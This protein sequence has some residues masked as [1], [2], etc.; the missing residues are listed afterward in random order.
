[1][2]LLVILPLFL[3]AMT[4]YLANETNAAIQ[5]D[6]ETDCRSSHILFQRTTAN[7]FVCVSQETAERWED[8]G[9]GKIVG[10]MPQEETIMLSKEKNPAYRYTYGERI[11]NNQSTDQIK[12]YIVRR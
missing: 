12:D 7:D 11:F 10:E 1:M 6:S 5:D 2:G 8:L 4:P 3:I 9:L